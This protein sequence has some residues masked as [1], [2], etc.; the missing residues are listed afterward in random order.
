MRQN[1]LLILVLIFFTLPRLSGQTS[2]VDKK[3]GIEINFTV[4]NDMFPDHWYSGKIKGK[5]ASLSANEYERVTNIL[6]RALAKY[7]VHILKENLRRIYALNTLNF[8][9]LPYG[10]TFSVSKK[11]VYITDDT[12]LYEK[13]Q[14]I[15]SFFHHELSS[16]LLRKYR[17][18]IGKKAWKANNPDDFHY[19]KGGIEAIR[20]GNSSMEYDSTLNDK[21]FLNRYSQSSPE[22]DMNVFAQNIFNGGK[23]FWEI[24]DHYDK[25]RAK[26]L[27]IISFYHKIDQVFT[28]ESFRKM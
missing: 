6:N 16:I 14:F 19:G 9:G 11:T 8:Y 22:E 2:F 20:E 18:S 3:T 27:L 7:P 15:E 25:I 4:R 5:A 1:F 26:T 12:A 17:C 10:G 24:V 13:D 21:G 28:E 23:T